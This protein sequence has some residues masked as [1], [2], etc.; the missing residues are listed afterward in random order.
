MSRSKSCPYNFSLCCPPE[1]MEAVNTSMCQKTASRRDLG[2]GNSCGSLVLGTSG[3]L[4]QGVFL[5]SSFSLQ[6]KLRQ[7]LTVMYG[8]ING[9]SRALEDVRA[10]QQEV[11]VRDG[12]PR[13]S[14][15]ANTA[16][17]SEQLLLGPLTESEF[18]KTCKN[19]HAQ[20]DS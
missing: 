14:G 16:L 3:G 8:Q 10:R 5:P 13:P 12:A 6:N 7:K 19:L 4:G 18:N 1:R 11:Q 15:E 9:A 2:G 20:R 17:A